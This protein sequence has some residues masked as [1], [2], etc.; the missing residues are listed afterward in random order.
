MKLGI[1]RLEGALQRSLMIKP[2]Q[3]YRQ[4]VAVRTANLMTSD[5]DFRLAKTVAIAMIR[6]SRPLR[7]VL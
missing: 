2:E 4:R 6:G 7:Q 1:V 3:I 5:G